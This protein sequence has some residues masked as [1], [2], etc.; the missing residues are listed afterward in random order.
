MELRGIVPAPYRWRPREQTFVQEI[1][2]NWLNIELACSVE[3]K[4]IVDQLSGWRN[5]EV[6]NFVSGPNSYDWTV[7]FFQ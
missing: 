4:P 7:R 1:V 5:R 6:Y 2:V 3:I